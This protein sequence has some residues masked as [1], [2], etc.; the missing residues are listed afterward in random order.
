MDQKITARSPIWSTALY[1][2]I[3]L[4]IYYE[5]GEM[6]GEVIEL[7]IVLW[8]QKRKHTGPS[9]PVNN[10]KAISLFIQDAQNFVALTLNASSS[11]NRKY[12]EL[13]KD[14]RNNNS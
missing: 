2:G 12:D 4:N 7:G 1:D 13:D 10:Y 9:L 11:I 8:R 3:Y 14:K 6:V 5:D